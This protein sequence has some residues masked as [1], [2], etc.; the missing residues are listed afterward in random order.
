MAQAE[1][2]RPRQASTSD[3]NQRQKIL[4]TGWRKAG[5]SSCIKTV[6]QHVPV[7]DVPYIG[8]TQ[9]IEK[10]NY[11]TIVPI[12]LWDTPSNFD[13]DQLDAPLGS[14]STLVY[15]MDMQQD[16]SYHD[17][18]RQ[19]VHTIMRGYLAN[20]AMKF[21]VFIHKAE[22]LSE[23]YRGENYSEIQ[24]A[25]TEELEDFQYSS[26]QAYA[27]H[28]DL[29][30]SGVC[31][32]IFNHMV[33]EIKFDMTSVHDVSLRDAWSKVLQ[34]IMEMLPAVEALLLNFTETSGMDNSYLFDIA[35]GVVLATDNRHRNDATMEQ[36]TEYLSRFLQFREIYRHLAPSAAKSSPK[37]DLEASDGPD[38]AQPKAWWD[39]E[40]TEAPWM[41]QATRL[42]PN[43]TIALW[44]FTPQL[45]LVVL[46]RTDTWH[47]RRGMIEYNLTF[48]RQGVRRILM[49]V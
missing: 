41:T 19:A 11:D 24:R 15:V 29:S 13:I 43:T 22:A 23:D 47:A 21:S 1:S 44:Q 39:D 37:A 40:D 9:K 20:P 12:Q 42:L 30:D 35:S 48:L 16:D 38:G 4:V 14:F 31:N 18:V 33:A 26:L 32:N 27:P 3:D 2:S 46:L 7:K 17:A 10:I 8:I 34:G 25:M 28:L 5:K 49:E 45:A 36:V 6:F